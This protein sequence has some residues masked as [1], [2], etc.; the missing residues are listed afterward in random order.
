M[1]IRP[2]IYFSVSLRDYFQPLADKYGF[3]LEQPPYAQD[4]ILGLIFYDYLSLLSFFWHE[5][6]VLYDFRNKNFIGNG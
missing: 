1:A 5:S 3:K 2:N 4:G 6:E